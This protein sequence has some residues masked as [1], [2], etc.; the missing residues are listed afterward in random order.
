MKYFI[1]LLF[2]V[3]IYAEEYVFSASEWVP[4]VSQQEEDYGF[5][6]VVVKEAL[7]Y[8]GYTAT[9]RF[10]PNKRALEEAR[11]NRTDGTF[12]WFPTKE[13]RESFLVSDPICFRQMHIFIRKD[14]NGDIKTI[15]DL[16]KYKVAVFSDYIYNQSLEKAEANGHL[17]MY[18]ISE[19]NS[20]F[21]LLELGRVDIVLE[22]YRTGLHTIVDQGL[23]NVIPYHVTLFKVHGLSVFFPKTEKH[24][25]LLQLFNN[26]LAH[27][28]RS[29]RFDA[30]RKHYFLNNYDLNNLEVE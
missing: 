15:E 9:F 26:G 6:S 30:L 17:E 29:G 11:L 12:P 7:A 23:D 28:K 1:F 13:R 4:Y 8:Y 10:Y 18:R 24:E 20:V 14:F 5:A 25:N 2:S 27:L 16:T 21:E 19:R 3:Q 22:D